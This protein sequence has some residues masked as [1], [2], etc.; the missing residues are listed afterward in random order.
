MQLHG[1]GERR[2]VDE[3]G[4][5]VLAERQEVAWQSS[6]VQVEMDT[7]AWVPAGDWPFSHVYI[8]WEFIVLE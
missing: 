3:V 1:Q 8:G 5:Y 6:G 2:L 7:P 4:V